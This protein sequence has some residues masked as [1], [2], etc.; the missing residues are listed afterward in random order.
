MLINIS[1]FLLSS[2]FL[3]YFIRARSDP[4]NIPFKSVKQWGPVLVEHACTSSAFSSSLSISTS[5]S[6][7]SSTAV[8]LL[9]DILS[10]AAIRMRECVISMLLKTDPQAGSGKLYVFSFFFIICLLI[11]YRHFVVV[12]SFMEL[13]P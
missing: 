7:S 10:S 2:Y 1:L 3:C 9:S 5:S 4:P 11:Y 12:W 13:S 6:S 8:S